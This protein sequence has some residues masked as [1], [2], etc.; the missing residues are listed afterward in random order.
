MIKNTIKKCEHD[1]RKSLCKDCGGGSL[2]NSIKS[3]E[4]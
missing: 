3:H 2:Y 4:V 1:K